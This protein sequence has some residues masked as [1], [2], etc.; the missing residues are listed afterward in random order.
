MSRKPSR[1]MRPIL[2]RGLQ[3]AM[4]LWRDYFEGPVQLGV[5][6]R[7]SRRVQILRGTGDFKVSRVLFI[8]TTIPRVLNLPMGGQRTGRWDQWAPQDETIDE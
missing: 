3:Q 5:V 8:W 6:R 4:V 1:T 7:G 2:L